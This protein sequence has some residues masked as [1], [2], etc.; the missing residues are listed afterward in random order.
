MHSAVDTVVLC[1]SHCS[2]CIEFDMNEHRKQSKESTDQESRPVGVERLKHRN[3]DA[4]FRHVCPHVPVVTLY[5]R[6]ESLSVS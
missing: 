4:A 5:V 3:G 2:L 6:L 1:P